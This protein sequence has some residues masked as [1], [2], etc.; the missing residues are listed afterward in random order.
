M[1]RCAHVCVMCWGPCVE[2][3]ECV[4][5]S[6]AVRVR[7]RALAA[8]GGP[9]RRGTASPT[10]LGASRWAVWRHQAARQPRAARGEEEG[11]GFGRAFVCA[12]ARGES[13]AFV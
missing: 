9:Q 5:M 12:A 2:T 10:G 13:C 1:S 3:L 4:Y 8:G 11:S 6:P 7:A